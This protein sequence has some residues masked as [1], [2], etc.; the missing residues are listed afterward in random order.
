MPCGQTCCRQYL[1]QNPLVASILVQ[2]GAALRV[3]AEDHDPENEIYV[4]MSLLDL[5]GILQ[6]NDN[7]AY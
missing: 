5:E 1:Q 7:I 3:T 4:M 6:A 2:C